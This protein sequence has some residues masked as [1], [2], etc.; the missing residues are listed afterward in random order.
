[1]PLGAG[2]SPPSSVALCRLP[3]TRGSPTT[4]ASIPITRMGPPLSHHY[5]P[6]I[7][8]FFYF[9]RST[10]WPLVFIQVLLH[11]PV[12]ISISQTITYAT[13]GQLFSSPLWFFFP[14]S[15]SNLLP[16]S[17]PYLYLHLFPSLF[18]LLANPP[19]LR[20]HLQWAFLGLSRWWD[21]YSLPDEALANGCWIMHGARI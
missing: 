13:S 7:T 9:Y 14:P 1:M 4:L 3:L 5:F 19:T 12:V 11:F 6:C 17:S 20:S 10:A 18:F 16:I 2:I 15:D 8:L 21:S